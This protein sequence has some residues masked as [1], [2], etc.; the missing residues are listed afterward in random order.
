M[1]FSSLREIFEVHGI[2]I[3]IDPVPYIP[4]F[5]CLRLFIILGATDPVTLN[6]PCAKSVVDVADQL[7]IIVK[8]DRP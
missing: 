2:E 1:F 3:T 6:K 8:C 4:V 7:T 5:D